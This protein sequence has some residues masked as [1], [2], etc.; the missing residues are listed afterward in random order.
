MTTR[1]SWTL[2]ADLACVLALAI[3]G[4][5]SHEPGEPFWVVLRIAW[6]FALA[7]LVAHLVV[8]WWGSAA[9]RLWP[10]GVAVVAI[11]Y[12]LGMLVRGLSGRGLAPG[13]LVVALLFLTATMLGWRLV[14]WL[15]ERRR[16]RALSVH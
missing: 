7:A 5:G 15:V 1:R 10:S 6:P 2:L 8:R 13:F 4:R 14:L 9:T 16:D 11:T 3:G 12:G